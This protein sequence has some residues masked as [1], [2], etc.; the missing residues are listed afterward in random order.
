MTDDRSALR[1]CILYYVNLRFPEMGTLYP[2]PYAEYVIL[3]SPEMGK[4]TLHVILISQEMCKYALYEFIILL[5]ILF[6]SQE[7]VKCT[8]ISRNGGSVPCVI[9]V[10]PEMGKCTLC[11]TLVSQEM[12]EV[13]L[14]RYSCISQK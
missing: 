1:K 7:L 3:V 13:Y 2:I 6:V 9:P 14:I 5:Q 8:C 4:C 10:S 11:V 12:V